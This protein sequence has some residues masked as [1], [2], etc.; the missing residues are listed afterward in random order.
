MNTK[1]TQNNLKVETISSQSLP[2][3]DQNDQEGQNIEG[4][5]DQDSQDNNNNKNQISNQNQDE[6]NIK[7]QCKCGKSYSRNASLFNH[8]RIKHENKI[9]EWKIFEG[10]RK[11]G[12][13]KKDQLTGQL[14]MNGVPGQEQMDMHGLK[15]QSKKEI[16]QEMINGKKYY[17]NVKGNE[18]LSKVKFND[19]MNQKLSIEKRLYQQMQAAA[20]NPF[21]FYLQHLY[22]PAAATA[23]HYYQDKFALAEQQQMWQQRQYALFLQNLQEEKPRHSLSMDIIIR[24]KDI[25]VDANDEPLTEKEEVEHLIKLFNY[26]TSLFSKYKI[27]Y[28]SYRGQ[29]ECLYTFLRYWMKFIKREKIDDTFKEYITFQFAKIL[30]VSIDQSAVMERLQKIYDDFEKKSKG[31]AQQN[32]QQKQPQQSTSTAQANQSATAASNATSGNNAAS[33]QQA[34][35]PSESQE[36]PQGFPIH[37][38]YSHLYPQYPKFYPPPHYPG[39]PNLQPPPLLN[40]LNFPI[41]SEGIYPPGLQYPPHGENDPTFH[42]YAKQAYQY[43]LRPSQPPIPYPPYLD[44]VA[45]SFSKGVSNSSG[46]SKGQGSFP[47]N[48]QIND[49]KHATEPLKESK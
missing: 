34:S 36:L 33:S 35:S 1:E 43:P 2:D 20:A 3:D 13:P 4:L 11:Q 23:G 42:L 39:L 9:T 8:I 19:E 29:F 40:H 25:L 46:A 16:S 17:E 14:G 38:P 41:P 5:N 31:T 18:S 30:K 6:S 24:F 47:N 32:G 44:G 22:N 7:F 12:R 10:M 15:L 27:D 26:Q 37:P 28:D 21:P 49:K 45:A 48:L